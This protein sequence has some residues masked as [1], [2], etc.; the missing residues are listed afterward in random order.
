M[1][2][3]KSEPKTFLKFFTWLIFLRLKVC[4]QKFWNDRKPKCNKASM[5]SSA[6][7]PRF[8]INGIWWSTSVPILNLR[9]MCFHTSPCPPKKSVSSYFGGQNFHA[10][11]PVLWWWKQV[12]LFLFLSKWEGWHVET[13]SSSKLE[14]LK[15]NKITNWTTLSWLIHFARQTLQTYSHSCRG[16]L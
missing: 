15:L 11:F 7:W 2:Y 5:K 12:A 6:K 1:V 4:D 16:I 9:T 14:I 8:R 10:V 3:T 13:Y